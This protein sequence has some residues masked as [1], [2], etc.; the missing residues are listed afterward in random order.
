M[1]TFACKDAGFNCEW[2]VES[3]DEND[4]LRQA[5]E[6]GRKEHG[7]KEMTKDLVD[8]VKSKIHDFRA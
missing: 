1:K 5:G 6:H 8:K 7:I 2:H 3:N 4:I